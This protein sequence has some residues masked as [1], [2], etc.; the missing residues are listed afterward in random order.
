MYAKYV[1]ALRLPFSTASV[2]PYIFGGIAAG[3]GFKSWGFALGLGAVLFTHLSA[4]LMNDY[5]DSKS[6]TDWKDSEYFG[7]FG[8][9]KL[10]QEGELSEQF[11][12]VNSVA[13]GVVAFGCVAGLA[14]LL[15]SWRVIA[16]FAGIIVLGWQY[17]AKPLALSYRMMGE[18]C[19]FLLFGPAVVM[20]AVFIQTGEFPTLEGFML[21][22]PFGFFTTAILFS[23]EVPDFKTDYSSGK[24][25]LVALTG[26]EKAWVAYTLLILAGVASLVANVMFKY[27]RPASLMGLAAIVPAIG[28]AYVLA[29]HY[30]DRRKLVKSS[31]LTILA[32]LLLGLLLTG[33]LFL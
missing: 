22:L 12:L 33:S 29:K 1:R 10:I 8:G 26:G 23:N 19:I 20:G 5:A 13:Y 6:G 7:F 2:M 27:L 25:N 32:H 11:Y 3:G 24:T 17:S 28:A 9:S 4:N 21:S 30:K 31:K 15:G 14:L 16:Y 18:P